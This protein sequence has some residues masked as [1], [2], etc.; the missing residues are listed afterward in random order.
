MKI[1]WCQPG[2][3]NRW[4]IISKVTRSLDA[5]VCIMVKN[6]ITVSLWD[7]VNTNKIH[8][9]MSMRKNR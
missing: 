1:N 2:D 4:V 7:R 3:P 9:Y 8:L 6:N 5:S